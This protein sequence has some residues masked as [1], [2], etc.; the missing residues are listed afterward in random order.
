MV[1]NRYDVI[2]AGVGAM[3]SAACYHLARRGRR[4]L[5]LERFGIPHV[6]G[7]SHGVNRIIRLAYYEDPSY[8]P[9]LRRA[10]ELWRSLEGG[11]GEQLLFV[12]GSIDA[13]HGD[14]RVFAESLRSC[15]L[16][17]LPHETLT[18]SELRARFPGIQ[19]PDD[20]LAVLQ[21]DGGFVMS[22]RAI[23]AHVT[24]ALELGAEIHGR[25]RSWN[26][27]RR[28]AGCAWRRTEAST[29]RSSSSSRPEPGWGL[30]Y[31]S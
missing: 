13:S 22:E 19:L 12:T 23:V 17:E 8:V 2:V 30:S 26:G 15:Q 4:V 31:Q 11:F 27:G 21:P 1:S 6:M 25:E 24:A 18:G 9:L 28:R 29:R 3:G 16:H 20:Y 10:F 14:T 7:S 5:G